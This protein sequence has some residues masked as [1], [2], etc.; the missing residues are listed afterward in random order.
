VARTTEWQTIE[1]LITVK[2]YPSVSTT[3]GKPCA[4]PAFV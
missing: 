3:Y 4:S 1:V 2:A